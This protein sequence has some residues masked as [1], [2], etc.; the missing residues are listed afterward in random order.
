MRTS[1]THRPPTPSC[2]HWS[3]WLLPLAVLGQPVIQTHAADTTA[4]ATPTAS[5]TAETAADSAKP[6]FSLRL[7]DL[8]LGPFDFNP[9]LTIG[10]VYDDNILIASQNPQSDLIWS[11]QPAV[12]V[13]AGDRSTMTEYRL[14]GY[15]VMYLSPGTFITRPQEGWPGKML[16]LDY[17]PKFNGFTDHS[18]ND[19]IDQLGGFNALWPLAKAILGVN[20]GYRLENTTIIEAGR[21]SQQET[22]PTSLMAG[23]QFS[24][25]TSA[26]LN[27]RRTS[28]NYEVKDLTGYTDWSNDNWFNFQATPLLNVGGGVTLGTLD[29]GDRSQNYEQL[30]ARARYQLA[31]RVIVGLSLGGEVRQFEDSSSTVEPIFSLDATYRPLDQTTITLAGYRRDLPSV[32]SGYNYLL[33]GISANVRQQI[34]DR[35]FVQVGA[36]YDNYSYLANARQTVTD[37]SDN[38]FLARVSFD[39]RFT[40]HLDGEVFYQFRTLDSSQADG[41]SNNQAGLQLTL[42]Y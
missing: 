13:V 14:L 22:I 19:S 21:R 37:R 2:P 40:K 17:G 34:G 42:K 35:Y 28:I 27:L 18:E 39:V 1:S 3:R 8:R 9:R 38:Y 29:S 26:E 15:D 33:T 36:A 11:V 20:Q 5:P 12:R 23:Y 10:V 25:K 16:M 24:E 6:A 30:L 4:S 7:P 41:F 31:E 32:Y